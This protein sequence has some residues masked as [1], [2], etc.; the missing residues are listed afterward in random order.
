MYL[1]SVYQKNPYNN[2]SGY[3]QGSFKTISALDSYHVLKIWKWGY[4]IINKSLM[5]LPQKFLK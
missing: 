2:D 4:V 1:Q 3:I 5:N